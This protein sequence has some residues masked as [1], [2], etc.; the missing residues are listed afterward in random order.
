MSAAVNTPTPINLDTD[1]NTAGPIT[2]PAGCSKITQI[3]V[4]LAASIV[5]VGSAGVTVALKLTGEGLKDGQ[6]ELDV[7]GVREDTTSTGGF[8]ALAPNE[9][10]TDINVIAGNAINLSYVMGGVDPGSPEIGVTLV[11]E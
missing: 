5:A 11:F 7:G 1:G 10:P 9:I 6:Q 2:V 3:L 4:S 8:K